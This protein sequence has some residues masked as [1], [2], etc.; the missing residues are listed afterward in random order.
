MDGAGSGE[1]I[2]INAIQFLKQSTLRLSRERGIRIQTRIVVVNP[3][4]E[5]VTGVVELG[6]LNGISQQGVAEQRIVQALEFT[7]NHACQLE[8]LDLGSRELGLD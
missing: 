8:S 6:P 5:L 1:V 7:S 3:G 2:V 4:I